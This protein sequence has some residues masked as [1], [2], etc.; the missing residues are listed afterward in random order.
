MV[1]Q[2][3]P[4][5]KKQSEAAIVNVSSGLA[6]VPY[7]ISPIYCASK[8]GIHSFTQS[9]RIQ[10]KN[11]SIK[12]FELA[13]PATDTPL[14]QTFDPTD[15]NGGL[16]SV[17]K[18]V[19]QTIEALKKDRLEICPGPSKVLRLLSRLAPQFILNQLSK[20]VDAML[21]KG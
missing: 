11:T 20:P 18:L 12:V 13:P 3:L 21:A 9:L 15:L 5:L 1:M 8:A 10:L 14:N 16:M 4:H 19:N 7:P 6:F 2:F 17:T